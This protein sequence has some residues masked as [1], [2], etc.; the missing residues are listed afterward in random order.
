MNA[1]M[2]LDIGEQIV[3]IR[4]TINE[5]S[6]N[7]GA[8]TFDLFD[9]LAEETRQLTCTLYRNNPGLLYGENNPIGRF[10]RG[11][12]DRLCDDGPPTPPPASQ[13]TG[14]QCPC[15]TYAGKA[16]R[17]FPPPTGPAGFQSFLTPGRIK[18]LR[19]VFTPEGGG[20]PPRVQTFVD[21]YICD[22]TG[23][24][25]G[26]LGSISVGT[27]TGAGITASYHDA[28]FINDVVLNSG[29]PDTCGD[30]P[31]E[32]PPQGL[33]V[34]IFTRNVTIVLNDGSTQNY[35]LVYNPSPST[36]PINVDINGLKVVLDFGGFEF[37]FGK[38]TSST[39]GEELPDG[40]KHPLPAPADDI[41]KT[42]PAPTIPEPNDTEYDEETRDETDDKEE[43]IGT[44]I[45]FV[46]V[47]V[48]GIPNDAKKQFGDGA[49]DVIYAGWFEF[50]ADGFNYP[51]QPIHFSQCLYRRPLGATGYAYTLYSGFSGFA[52][53]YKKKLGGT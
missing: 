44:E 42:L 25:T 31:P 4:R 53:I 33:D 34:D 21:Y 40:E 1:D 46:R 20:F 35:N 38:G 37:N 22:G 10:Q 16:Q 51:R 43:D 41:N 2:Y 49:P 13:F 15:E 30:P 23:T 32:Y 11:Y 19:H 9:R 18:G 39:G 5:V 6:E 28:W 8:G 14:G 47:T 17:V 45:E 24:E 50:Q 52:T 7:I 26:A 12:L 3:G 36:F 48:S 27:S 29:A